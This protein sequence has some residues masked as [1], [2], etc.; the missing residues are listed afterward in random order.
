MIHHRQRLPLSLE[1]GYDRSR[2]HFQLDD[3]Q[4]HAPSHGGLLL[5]YV[6]DAEPTFADFFQEAISADDRLIGFKSL[7]YG[8]GSRSASSSVLSRSSV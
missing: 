7:R 8:G 4:G 3:L 6:D 2:V 1:A 5:G